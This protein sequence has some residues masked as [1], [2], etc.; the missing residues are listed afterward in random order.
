MAK[1]QDNKAAR[2]RKQ[3]VF[4]A[5]AGVVFLGLIVIQG[6]KLLKQVRGSE[7]AAPRSQRSRR[8]ASTSARATSTG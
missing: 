5:V 8:S 4:L 3:K 7:S 2:E 6:P 1:K